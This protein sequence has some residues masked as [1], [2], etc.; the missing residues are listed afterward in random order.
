MAPALAG[1]LLGL[2][3]SAL[4][5]RLLEKLVHGV[6]TTDLATYLG[7]ATVL[8]GVALLACAVPARAATRVDPMV[9]MRAE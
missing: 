5:S 7:T 4:A 2:A 1:V 9:A 6:S 8:T 3:L